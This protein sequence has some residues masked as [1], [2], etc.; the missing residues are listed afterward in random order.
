[1][2]KTKDENTEEQ[3]LVAAK[4]VFQTKGMDGA[5]MQH[6]ADEAGINKAMLH[7]Y[8]RSKQLLFEAVFNQAFSLLA[9]Q[10]NIILNDESSIEDKVK[11][12]TVN[13]TTFMMKHPYLPNFII[14]ELNRNEDFIVKLKE[15]TGFPNLDKFKAQVDAEINDGLLNPID[16]DQLF[17]NIIALNIF[18]FLG[19]P[20]IK[21]FTNKDEQD[22]ETFVESRK[23]EVANFIINS[24]KPH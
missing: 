4:T 6:I 19:K 11:N 14:Q 5:R 22:Y 15:N 9:P 16:A 21:A 10:L 3:I 18:P 1:M 7:Y 24:I 12:F 2:A 13:Y 23:T 17:V 8:F 20:L